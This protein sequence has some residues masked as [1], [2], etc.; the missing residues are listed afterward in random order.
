MRG[1]QTTDERR[2]RGRGVDSSTAAPPARPQGPARARVRV[3]AA[4]SEPLFAEALERALRAGRRR[5]E[6]VAVARTGSQALE[7]IGAQ[8]PDVAVLANSLSAPDSLEILAATR[9]DRSSTKV[10]VLD[11]SA[12]AA[13]A[14]DALAAGAS[15]YVGKEQSAATI[16]DTIIQVA[17][18]AK[19]FARAGLVR[20]SPAM[21]D[22][23]LSARQHQILQRFADGATAG[24]IA[25]ELRISA[26]TVTE[27]ATG[28]Y[29]SLGANER[30]AAIAIALRLGLIS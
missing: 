16:R 7:L 2:S 5:I 28:A 12:D 14:A 24:E 17:A 4:D 19:P 11:A 3:L 26:S 10:I 20:C 9:A 30:A 1:A 13:V 18:G 22:P 8:S 23:A 27:D 29:R 21:P 15:A 25:H 6:L